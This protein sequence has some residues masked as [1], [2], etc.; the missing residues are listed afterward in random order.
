MKKRLA[1]IMAALMLTSC[2]AAP[3]PEPK[4]TSATTT[5]TPETTTT[6][7]EVITTTAVAE[8]TV[9]TTVTTAESI[10]YNADFS[11]ADYYPVD[12]TAN[13]LSISGVGGMINALDEEKMEIARQG[14]YESE[15][16]AEVIKQ[17]KEIFTLENGEY[18]ITTELKPFYADVYYNYFDD[19]EPYSVKPEMVY[20]L[21]LTLDGKNGHVFVFSIPLPLKY[22][23]WSGENDFYV[24]VYVT[25]DN[26]TVVV[27]ECCQQTLRSVTPLY[28]GD[29]IQLIFSSGHTQ[30]TSLSTIISFTDSGYNLEL[31]GSAIEYTPSGANYILDDMSV[32]YNEYRILCYDKEKGYIDATAVKVNGEVMDIISSSPDILAVFPDI[33][34]RC[35]SGQVYIIAGKYITVSDTA[36]FIFENG[37]FKLFDGVIHPSSDDYPTLAFIAQP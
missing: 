25:P 12:E 15:Y 23:E 4:V 20:T 30:G 29:K 9:E 34:E 21:P 27:P 5:T 3:V 2:D 8:T 24:T 14:V 22:A 28:V 13:V 18:V 26:K 1:I 16:Y 37:E 31:M 19:R 6:T 33:I 35:A 7:T 10:N 11:L 17:A 36:T 32:W